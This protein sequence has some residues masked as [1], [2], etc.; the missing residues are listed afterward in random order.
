L[1][2]FQQDLD[3]RP[4]LEP[5]NG[6][7][8]SFS[9]SGGLQRTRGLEIELSGQPYVGLTIG[10]A[11][12]WLDA[13]YID[14]RDTSFGLTPVGT[15]DRQSSLF[16]SYELPTG[17]LRG[18]GFGATVISVGDR[19]IAFTTEQ[20]IGGYERID[21][22]AY[23]KGI[24]RLDLSLQVRN[25]LDETYIERFRQPGFGN[26]FGAPRAFLFRVNWTF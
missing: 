15:I 11:S 14:E 24:P 1:A 25:L 21:L 22:Q 20:F 8:E 18:L 26:F 6:P 16:T 23:Y 10:A 13:E 9:I 5:T 2:L 17:R 7:G 12:A 19:S 4:I 3:N